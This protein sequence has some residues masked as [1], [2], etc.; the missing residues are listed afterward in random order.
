MNKLIA[1]LASFLFLL[2]ACLLWAQEGKLQ[3]IPRSY[4]QGEPLRIS[5][6]PQ[7]V[8]D[9]YIVEDRWKLTRTRG[10]VIKYGRNPVVVQDKPWEE[11]VGGSPSVLWD[12]QKKKYMMWYTCFS[13]SNYFSKKGPSYY[14]GYA[15]SEDAYNWT[16]PKLQDFPFAG[17]DATNII[18]TGNNKR[19]SGA[20]VMFNPDQSD[21]KK[22]FLIVYTGSN[23]FS[24]TYS[25]DGIHWDKNET[26]LLRYHSDYPNHLVWVPETNLWHMYVR[27]PIRPGGMGP[28]PEGVRH[29]GRPRG[30]DDEPEP[31]RVGHAAH[32]LLS[33]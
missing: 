12:P 13:L 6:S 17:H 2:A 14:I 18:A 4:Y 23:G 20:Q 11:A 5:H 28:L 10:T 30:A 24:L 27:S 8:F 26:R 9:D 33:R 7:F 32:H 3:Q 22:R 31:H 29:T 25:A 21:P 19:A 15:E 1:C 16:K